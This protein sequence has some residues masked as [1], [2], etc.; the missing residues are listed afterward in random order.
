MHGQFVIQ[1][2]EN[3][4]FRFRLETAQRETILR[5]ERYPTKTDAMNGIAALRGHAARAG[6]F[7]RS[8]NRGS[9]FTFTIHS[10][11]G[12]LIASGATYRSE[13]SRDSAIAF[14]MQHARDATLAGNGSDREIA[15]AARRSS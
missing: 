15:G 1:G 14:V 13:A 12:S 11:R 3:V 9:G 10:L 4:G 8:G 2:S 5:S 7:L 6:N